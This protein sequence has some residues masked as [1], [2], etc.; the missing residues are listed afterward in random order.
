MRI[1]IIGSG[2]VA[3]AFARAIAATA[4][5][6]LQ[7]ICAR[8]EVRGRELAE[9][10]GTGYTSSPETV[11]AADLYLIAV[12]DAAVGELSGRLAA[13]A[14]AVVAHTAGGLG[15]D[16]LRCA[17]PH[18]GVLYPLQT[19]SSGRTIDFRS[20]PLLTE[21]SDRTAQTCIETAAAALSERVVAADSA[22]RNRIHVAAVFAC[23]FTNH[24]L[25]RATRLL[26]EADIN[27]A[28]LR[29]LIHETIDKALSVADP[30]AVQT[31]PAARHDTITLR[32]H[33]AL[34]EGEADPNYTAIY[35][36]LSNSI[37]EISKKI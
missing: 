37:W 10:Y 27:A 16:A 13:P 4:G 9:R 21:A 1:T 35:Q 18:R 14:E 5:L 24:L 36:L 15:L 3:A 23:N 11:G 29:P 25:A 28:L 26:E 19:F 2:N 32:R 31:G 34:L 8:N 20:V 6:R 7:E 12:S 33:L 22:M 17:T 30:A